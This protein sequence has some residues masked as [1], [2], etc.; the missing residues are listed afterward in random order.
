MKIKL[1][2]YVIRFIARQGIRHVFLLPG[3]GCMHL[4]DSLGRCN[5]LEKICCLHEQGAVI[6]AEAYGQFTNNPGVALVTTGPGG[7]N[8]ITGVAGAWIDSTPL[9]VISG[10]AKRS[11]LIGD[12]GVRQMGIQEVDIVRIVGSITKHAVTIMDPNSIRYHLEKAVFLARN[13][14]PGPV[15]IDIPLD[16][17]GAVIDEDD[18]G[19]FKPEKND[20][21]ETDGELE[22]KIET[23]ISL[24]NQSERPV[25]LAGN[26]I[27]LS[28]AEKEFLLLIES[29]KIPVLTTWKA[30]DFLPEDHDLYFGRPG[31]IGQRGANFIQQNSDF[32]LTIGA[33]LDL[34]QVGH[35]YPNFAREAR[36]VIVD[37]DANEIRKMDMQVDVPVCSDA[38]SFLQKLIENLSSVQIRDRSAWMSRCASWKKKYPVILPEYLEPKEPVNTYALVDVLSDLLTGKD[39]LVPGSSGSCSEITLQAFRVR[40]GQR[41]LNTPGLGSMGFGLPASIGACLASGKKRT[42]CIIGDGGLQ[43]NIQELETL[44][45]L[46][47]PVKLFVLNNNGY[48]S[49]RNTHNR[50]FAGRLVCCDP[51]SGLTLPDT[52]RVASA[53]GLPAVR[54]S[55]QKTLKTDIRRVLDMEGPIVCEVIIEPDLQTAPKA[56]SIVKPDGSI[57]S[58]PL[59]DLWPFLERTEFYNNMI[60]TPL[61]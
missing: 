34:A 53:Y 32:I 51:S 49:I 5:D 19:G 44:K 11:D 20:L 10:Q 12:L 27:R 8:A 23:V 36:K 4:V 52:C 56:T 1:S 22:R 3:G 46:N 7:T 2:D 18:L 43:H 40:N 25:I 57:E 31:S 60:I 26:G 16:V 15:W 55:G 14:R 13:G 9:I 59:E 61:E 48:A 45:R 29:L 37:I 24:I 47:I 54:I 6:A 50:L 39:V 42:V 35:S 58:R 28:N 41:I 30:I 38:K 33:R 21:P 17:Q